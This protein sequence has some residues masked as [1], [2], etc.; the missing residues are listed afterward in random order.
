MFICGGFY[1]HCCIH[2]FFQGLVYTVDGVFVGII[3][4]VV[5]FK[6]SALALIACQGRLSA[7]LDWDNVGEFNVTFKFDFSRGGL[8]WL[9]HEFNICISPKRYHKFPRKTHSS[10]RPHQLLSNQ[11]IFRFWF[12][13]QP[14]ICLSIKIDIFL[15][16]PPSSSPPSAPQFVCI[17]KYLYEEEIKLLANAKTKKKNKNRRENCLHKSPMP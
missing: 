10:L 7:R 12:P 13:I 4:A 3:V 16:Q 17:N 11:L 5:V 15:T 8:L 2:L 6:C 14:S 9:L 1:F